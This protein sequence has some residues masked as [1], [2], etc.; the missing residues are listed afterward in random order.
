MPGR[1]PA[2][3]GEK[4]GALEAS[5]WS[6]CSA[7]MGS[8]GGFWVRKWYYLIF[9]NISI[10]IKYMMGL[11]VFYSVFG[12]NFRITGNYKKSAQ[13]FHIPSLS[14]YILCNCGMCIKSGNMSVLCVF[15]C[16]LTQVWIPLM[17]TAVKMRSVPSAQ[18]S[19]SC[20]PGQ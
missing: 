16:S 7:E 19:P 4:I 12:N 3:I 20:C 1:R 13:G 18:R 17:T 6:L 11:L 14:S 9:L 5:E 15:L 8:R 2:G 10:F